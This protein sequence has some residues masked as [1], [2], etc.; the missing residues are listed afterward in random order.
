[1]NDDQ[2]ASLTNG[3]IESSYPQPQYTNSP[4]QPFFYSNI[5]TSTHFQNYQQ[6][7]HVPVLVHNS[8]LPSNTN[9]PNNTNI[10]NTNNGHHYHQGRYDEGRTW[11]KKLCNCKKTNA[12]YF[13]IINIEA[14]AFYFNIINIET[15]VFYF[16]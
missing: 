13:I 7:S 5:D 16:D 2:D 3:L 15:N 1:M 8:N 6:T 4:S 14:N 10:S 12:F 9:L 11:R